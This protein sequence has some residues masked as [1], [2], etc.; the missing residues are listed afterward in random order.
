M[1][2]KKRTVEFEEGW[3]DE[4]LAD[5]L[6]TQEELN[7]LMRGIVQMVET[8]QIVADSMAM[9]DLSE[10]EQQDIAELLNKPKDTRH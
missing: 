9:E 5:G 2:R 7:A 4:L 1:T 8:G 10:E 6:V 3:A